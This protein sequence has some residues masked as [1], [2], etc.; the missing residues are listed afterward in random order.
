MI[1]PPNTIQTAN[2]RTVLTL[3]FKIKSAKIIAITGFIKLMEIASE[4]GI[5]V[6]A[7]NIVVTQNHPKIV[8]LK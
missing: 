7:A 5:N 6:T 2:K 1:E 8:R 3:S 4:T